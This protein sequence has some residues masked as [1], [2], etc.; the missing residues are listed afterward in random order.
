MG[1]VPPPKL[2]G[3]V[4]GARERCQS[5]QP[6][7]DGAGGGDGWRGN[8]RKGRILIIFCNSKLFLEASLGG[9]QIGSYKLFQV[10]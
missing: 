3:H 6:V 5:I 7:E 8:M 10:P 2:N 1:E 9:K 4:P